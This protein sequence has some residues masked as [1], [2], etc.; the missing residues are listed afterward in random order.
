MGLGLGMMYFL[1]SPVQTSLHC[2]FD[3]GHRV[4]VAG[5][6]NLEGQEDFVRN[7]TE[8]SKLLQASCLGFRV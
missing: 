6:L 4:G 1:L 2:L 7:G 8:D 5:M 3:K